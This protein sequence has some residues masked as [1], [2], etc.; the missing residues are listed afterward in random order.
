MCYDDFIKYY[1]TMGIAKLHMD[2]VT[3][4]IN[5][6][7]EKNNNMQIIK[8]NINNDENHCYLQL[9]QINPRILLSDGT[10]QQTVLSFIMLVDN[11]FNYIDSMAS[12]DMHIAVEKKLKKG[13]YYLLCDVNYRYVNENNKNHGYNVTCYSEYNVELNNVT[14]TMRLDEKLK[15]AVMSY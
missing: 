3:S 7:I 9:Y 15:I 11:N 13:V 4:F 6:P 14:H 1:V 12:T 5:V 2:Y 10:Y 8:V